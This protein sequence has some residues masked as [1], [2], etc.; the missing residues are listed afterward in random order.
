MTL[1]R[2]HETLIRA[3]KKNSCPFVDNLAFAALFRHFHHFLNLS[4]GPMAELADAL[5]SKSSIL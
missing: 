2:A 3:G 5:D 1:P 4:N